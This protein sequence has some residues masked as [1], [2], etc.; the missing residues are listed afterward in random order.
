MFLLL[1]CLN[2]TN[3]WDSSTVNGGKDMFRD[4]NIKVSVSKFKK[5]H[6]CNQ[7]CQWSGFRLK[8]FRAEKHTSSQSMDK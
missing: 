8:S 6:I 4:G 2:I 7:Y 1:S 5:E 3:P